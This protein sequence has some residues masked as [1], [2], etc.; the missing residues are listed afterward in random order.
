[1][2][3]WENN[4]ALHFAGTVSVPHPERVELT[5]S[6]GYRTSAYFY[7]PEGEFRRA[8]VVYLHGIQSHPGWFVGSGCVLARQGHPVWSLTRR[9]SGLNVIGRGHALSG[10]QLLDD[11]ETVCRLAMERAGSSFVHLVGVSWGGKLAACFAAWANRRTQLG[12]LTLIAPGIVSQV[13]VSAMGKLAIAFCLFFHPKRRFEIPLNDVELFTDNEQMRDYLRGDPHRLH[14]ATAR[15]LYVS[16]SLDRMLRRTSLSW[17][18]PVT[19]ILAA[20]DRIIDNPATLEQVRRLAG[21]RLTLKQLEGAHT[22]EFE[23][24]PRAFYEALVDAVGDE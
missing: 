7:A 2:N 20:R 5:L 10:E 15:F 21:R 23:A 24:D 16:R 9:G 11:V 18:F 1:M 12:S 8:P 17:D 22:L 4:S 13:D 6:D 19:L 14:R 3:D